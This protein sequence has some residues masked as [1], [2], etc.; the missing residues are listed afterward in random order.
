[1]SANCNFNENDVNFVRHMTVFIYQ[2][3]RPPW[4]TTWCSKARHVGIWR[5]SWDLMQNSRA[6]K[7]IRQ[8]HQNDGTYTNKDCENRSSGSWDTSAPSEQVDTEIALLVVKKEEEITEGK[9]Y[10]PV[11]KF[12]ERAELLCI[13][14][15]ITRLVI[16][17]V[18]TVG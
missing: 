13:L 14:A 4:S 10:S 9:I 1:M 2:A 18:I 12:V 6:L 15:G 11:G 7:E 17:V 16:C 3:K 5:G 8:L